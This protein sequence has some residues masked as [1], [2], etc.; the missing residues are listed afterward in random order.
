VVKAL[1][2]FFRSLR[3]AVVLSLLIAAVSILATVIPQRRE[4]AFYA[5]TLSPFLAGIVL[6]AGLDD[7]F[8]SVVFLAP[9]GLF[10]A[11]L[12]VCTADR[13]LSRARRRARR[14][15]GPDL[16]HAGLLLLIAG[17]MASAL[18]RQ[19]AT[20]YLAP[21]EAAALPRGYALELL[22]FRDERYEDGRPRAWVS[23][24]RLSRRG[25]VLVPSFALE[26]NRPLRT[27]GLRVYQLA[28]A[29]QARA[30]L[31]DPGGVRHPISSGE[32]FRWEGSLLVLEALEGMEAP[33]TERAV[34]EQWEDRRRT[35]VLRV[36][37][38]E[39]IGPFVVEELA[40]H[41][42]SGL[43]AVR[44]PG[45]GPVLL[46]LIVMSAG[47]GLTFVQKSKDRQGDPQQ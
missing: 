5:H 10:A 28:Y 41:T 6:A 30:V 12:A 42:V 37:P 44:D 45:S 36:A 31:V 13:L 23:T 24:V 18:A 22:S 4:A 14:R 46:A 33:H 29:E 2:R 11:S 40:A 8:R 1:Y 19:E 27:H 32:G 3:L 38:G 17:A 7:V 25:Q 34:F 16:I 43:R 15:H 26:V 9:V 39:R 47:L 20:G 21:G 35:A